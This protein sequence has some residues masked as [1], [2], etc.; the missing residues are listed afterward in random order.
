MANLSVTAAQVKIISGATAVL[1]AGE[2]ITA[3]QPLY[4][5][6]AD[7]YAWKAVSTTAAEAATIGI[8]LCDCAAGQQVVYAIDE[9]VVELGAAAAP[10]AGMAYAVSDTAGLIQPEGDIGGGEFV[11]GLGRGIAGNRLRLQF[12]ALAEVHA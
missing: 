1:T 10:T 7:G 5:K 3:G 6:D 4:R 9:A 2:A 11:T 8:A 12:Q